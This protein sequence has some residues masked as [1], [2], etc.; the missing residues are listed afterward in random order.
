MNALVDT[1]VSLVLYVQLL[2]NLSNKQDRRT[3]GTAWCSQMG[4][5]FFRGTESGCTLP[6]GEIL[7]K[8][9]NLFKFIVTCIKENN[10]KFYLT[11]LLEAEIMN[12]KLICILYTFH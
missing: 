9:L 10:I 3:V 8:S 1:A 12:M 6:D 7:S 11:G 4:K 5:G 2:E